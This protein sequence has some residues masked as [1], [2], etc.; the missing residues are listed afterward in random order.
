ME[1]GST[2][3]YFKDLSSLGVKHFKTLF[4]APTK[5]SLAEV[6]RVAQFFPRYIEEEGN[7]NIMESVSKDD[8]R[9]LG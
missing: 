6:I 2:T 4:K 3:R 7:D 1:E 8:A 9:I 5:V